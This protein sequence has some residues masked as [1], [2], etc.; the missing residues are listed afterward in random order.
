MKMQLV[1]ETDF[2]VQLA[3]FSFEQHFDERGAIHWMQENW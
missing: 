3:E 2:H 1:N